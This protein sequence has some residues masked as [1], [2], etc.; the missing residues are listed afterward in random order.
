[1]YA[2]LVLESLGFEVE[3]IPTSTEEESDFLASIG[4][5]RLLIEEKTKVDDPDFLSKRSASL[6]EGRVFGNHVPVTPDN[7]ISGILRKAA[8]QLISSSD[9]PHDFRLVWF[10]G[11]GVDAEAKYEQFIAT[12]YGTT[13]IIEKGSSAFRRCYFFRNS[14]FFRHSAVIDGAVSASTSGRSV[15]AKLCL[16]LLSKNFQALRSSAAAAAFGNAVLDPQREEEEGVA[17]VLAADLDRRDVR[18]LLGHLQSKYKTDALMP[19]DLG[20]TSATIVP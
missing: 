12:L 16:N 5:C 18:A 17:F 4:G 13:N 3:D 11:A 9:V 14:E 1:M 6:S 15:H 10:T 2:R 7:R 20:Y 19:F 8:G